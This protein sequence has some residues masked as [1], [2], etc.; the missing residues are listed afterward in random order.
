MTTIASSRYPSPGEL[1]QVAEIAQNL[2]KE[3][4]AFGIMC[5]IIHTFRRTTKDDQTKEIK[6]T[7][8]GIRCP[9]AAAYIQGQGISLKE[10][11]SLDAQ[12]RRDNW[13]EVASQLKL[14]QDSGYQIS[15]E[16]IIRPRSGGG[17]EPSLEATIV[18]PP[19]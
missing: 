3:E 11:L 7:L 8:R 16:T 1:Q 6:L 19:F 18:L 10:F 14:L 5:R 12:H 9:I 2:P 15:L 17:D 13:D 4:L